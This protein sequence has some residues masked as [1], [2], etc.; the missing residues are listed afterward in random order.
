MNK[1]GQNHKN[2]WLSVPIFSS[3]IQ[4]GLLV[5]GHACP[6]LNFQFRNEAG[7]LELLKLV[8]K[9]L[10]EVE[11]SQQDSGSQDNQR[12]VAFHVRH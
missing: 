12:N 6:K 5:V 1:Q 3:I 10:P 2:V 9:N 11:N 8:Q 7:L 4:V